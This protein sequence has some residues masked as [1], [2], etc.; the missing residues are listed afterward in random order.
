V[1]QICSAY[2]D[3]KTGG[4][5]SGISTNAADFA[6]VLQRWLVPFAIRPLFVMYVRHSDA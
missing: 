2:D 5:V 3:G 1:K 4:E 6:T